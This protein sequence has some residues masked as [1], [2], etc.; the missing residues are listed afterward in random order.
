MRSGNHILISKML[1][2]KGIKNLISQNP[3]F[4]FLQ[5]NNISTELKNG[6]LLQVSENF[7][8]KV[9]K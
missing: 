1:L 6:N 7:C 2:T 8:Y 4:S 5:K 3:Y 9:K